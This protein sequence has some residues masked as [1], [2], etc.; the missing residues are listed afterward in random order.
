MSLSHLG[1]IFTLPFTRI[2]FK[3]LLKILVA[4]GIIS[5]VILSII[6]LPALPKFCLKFC[7]ARSLESTWIR[8]G[9]QFFLACSRLDMTCTVLLRH[10]K[11]MVQVGLGRHSCLYTVLSVLS[12]VSS[13]VRVFIMWHVMVVCQVGR[14]HKKECMT[15]WTFFGGYGLDFFWAFSGLTSRKD[16]CWTFLRLFSCS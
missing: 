1:V 6:A 14:A 16:Y 9:S 15:S 13:D 7:L 5:F 2:T 4:M 8:M 10:L 3:C 12:D 11:R